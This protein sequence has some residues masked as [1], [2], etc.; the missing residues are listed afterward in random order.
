MAHFKVVVCSVGFT[1]IKK[2]KEGDLG[3]LV[4]WLSSGHDPGFGSD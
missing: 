1:L 2:E 3:G 4:E